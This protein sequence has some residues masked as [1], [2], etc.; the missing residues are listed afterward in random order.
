ML[1]LVLEIQVLHDM[2]RLNRNDIQLLNN[3][4][5]DQESD[6]IDS[7]ELEN[8]ASTNYYHSQ[9]RERKSRSGISANNVRL[10][11]TDTEAE[12]DELLLSPGKRRQR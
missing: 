6:V 12:E 9:G 3:H 11:D 7:V 4:E 10:A 1:T 2:Q 8:R 5:V